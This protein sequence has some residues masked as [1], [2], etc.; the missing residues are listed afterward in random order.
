MWARGAGVVP[1]AEAHALRQAAASNPDKGKA[2]YEAARSTRWALH[3]VFYAVATRQ[4]Q[5]LAESLHEFNRLLSRA[6][7]HLEVSPAP[8]GRRRAGAALRWEWS[9]V[10]GQLERVLWP[11]VLAAANLL[12]SPEAGR[13]ACA[14]DPIADGC[15]STAAET[16][17]GVGARCKR[18]GPWRNR[19]S[20]QSAVTS[21]AAT[22]KSAA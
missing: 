14:P 18:A 11:V 3:E 22:I 15:M 13:C 21:C 7:H 9:G 10:P 6:Q 12:T 5:L 4:P 17:F 2:A 19:A 8:A 1:D 20:E 16:A